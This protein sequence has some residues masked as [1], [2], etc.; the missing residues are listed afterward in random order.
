VRHPSQAP[1]PQHYTH[2]SSQPNTSCPSHPAQFY[3]AQSYTAQN[4][5]HTPSPSPQCTNYN[6]P[7]TA[8][9][10]RSTNKH[11]KTH[12]CCS[13]HRPADVP[14]HTSSALYT[15]QR[16]ATGRRPS[17]GRSWRRGRY[18]FHWGG[19]G[20]LISAPSEIGP[21]K[22]LNG[23][24]GA[25]FVYPLLP[26]MTTWNKLPVILLA[27]P[28]HCPSFAASAGSR[29]AVEPQATHLMTVLGPSALARL[30]GS[31]LGSRS[32]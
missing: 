12:T 21:V 27:G 4:S 6:I 15:P 9:R 32:K 22:P 28:C 19:G 26:A 2:N 3:T 25:F 1:I 29:E 5:S 18:S 31:I 10:P 8:H 7:P 11:W 30:Q 24:W 23:G 13:S 20:R 17:Q 14:Y 16:R